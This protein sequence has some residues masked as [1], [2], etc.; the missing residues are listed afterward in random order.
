[1]K[2]LRK[3]IATTIR[4]YLNENVE[5]SFGKFINDVLNYKTPII[6]AE[7]IKQAK[8]NIDERNAKKLGFIPCY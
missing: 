1:M 6:T 2:D 7:T 3:F 8:Q 4:E 5:N